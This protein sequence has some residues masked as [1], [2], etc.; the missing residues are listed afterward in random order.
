M[1]LFILITALFFG[2]T[3]LYGQSAETRKQ[4]F[5]ISISV[6]HESLSIPL[7]TSPIKYSYNPAFLIST[8]YLLKKKDKHDFH[9]LGSVGYYYHKHWE[10]TIFSEIKF[11]YRYYLKRFSISPNI[12]VGYAHIFSP[13]PVYQFQNGQFTE[14]KDKGRSAFQ[15][16]LSII[17]SFKLFQREN[18]PEIY[19]TYSFAFQYPHSEVKGFHQ[20]IGIG[21]KFYPFNKK[22][23]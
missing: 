6:M 2:I 3:N 21:Y 8:E 9:L 10:S 20:F 1:R 11:G 23:Q 12:G 5:P 15:T 22:S 18:S 17:S 14:V 13:K 19:L 4:L 16:S 7:I